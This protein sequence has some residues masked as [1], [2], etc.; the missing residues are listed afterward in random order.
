MKITFLFIV[1]FSISSLAQTNFP[2]SFYFSFFEVA[3]SQNPKLE[4]GVITQTID[5]NSP[6]LAGS[7]YL[8]SKFTI[9]SEFITG[10]GFD[11]SDAQLIVAGSY[12]LLEGN[13][14]ISVGPAFEFRKNGLGLV[15]ALNQRLS[16]DFIFTSK[17]G[18]F[19]SPFDIGQEKIAL[20]SSVIYSANEDL[21]FSSEVSFMQDGLSRFITRDNLLILSLGADYRLISNLSLRGNLGYNFLVAKT[22]FVFQSGL[23]YSF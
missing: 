13:T 19:I 6:Y 3:N 16:D 17:L 10:S 14:S 2:S 11:R 4:A 5:N 7:I 20:G 15:G 9:T 8:G 1:I 18:M 12:N 23:S 21:F 22:D